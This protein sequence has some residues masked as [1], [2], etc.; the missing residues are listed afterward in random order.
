LRLWT[1]GFMLGL[2]LLNLQLGYSRYFGMEI[3]K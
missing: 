1:P 2:I 3:A